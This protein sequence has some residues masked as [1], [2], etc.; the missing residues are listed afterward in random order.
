MTLWDP[1]PLLLWDPAPL[2]GPR[3][4]TALLLEAVEVKGQDRLRTHSWT[5]GFGGANKVPGLVL[6][7]LGGL[8]L[9]PWSCRLLTLC[10]HNT[11]QTGGSGTMTTSSK[12]YMSSPSS[13]DSNT[14]TGVF[15]TRVETVVVTSCVREKQTV[16]TLGP[17]FNKE[18]DGTGNELESYRLADGGVV[19]LVDGDVHVGVHDHSSSFPV[20]QRRLDQSTAARHFCR[21]GAGGRRTGISWRGGG[22]E[23]RLNSHHDGVWLSVS[24]ALQTCVIL[25]DGS[26]LAGFRDDL[27]AR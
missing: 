9:P 12:V 2:P 3:A 1:A 17:G 4:L 11:G 20:L 24:L 14:L 8:D 5:G 18:T 22:E 19:T 27:L 10:K 21:G 16:I 13:Q 7:V 15:V 25:T 6:F 23:E 26:L